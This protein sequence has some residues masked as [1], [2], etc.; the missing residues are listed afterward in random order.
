LEWFILVTHDQRVFFIQ[1]YASSLCLQYS[2][3]K[4]QTILI[5]PTLKKSFIV[6]IIIIMTM[7][8]A[9]LTIIN[10]NPR[11]KIAGLVKRLS[12]L[13]KVQSDSA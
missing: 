1:P 10:R 4:V 12:Y 7:L 6:G 2:D 11:A 3:D 8:E 5:G 9:V 13:E